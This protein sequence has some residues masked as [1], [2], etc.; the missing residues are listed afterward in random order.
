MTISSLH[1]CILSTVCYVLLPQAYFPV[2]GFLLHVLS[3]SSPVPDIRTRISALFLS[4][5][6]IPDRFQYSL[7]SPEF[8]E[9]ESADHLLQNRT[10]LSPAEFSPYKNIQ[11]SHFPTGFYEYVSLLLIPPDQ[12]EASVSAPEVPSLLCI[13]AL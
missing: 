6:Q 3:G 4:H 7:H 10:G 8:P 5:L 1:F 9:P 12:G 13:C 11:A 2:C